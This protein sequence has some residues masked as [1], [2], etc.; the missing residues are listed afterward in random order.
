VD[1]LLGA[2]ADLWAG[3]GREREDGG[4]DGAAAVEVLLEGLCGCGDEELLG[5]G[6]EALDGRG[7]LGERG[8]EGLDRLERRVLCAQGLRVEVRGEEAEEVEGRLE[9]LALVRGGLCGLRVGRELVEGRQ[10]GDPVGLWGA[11]VRAER[12]VDGEEE[13]RRALDGGDLGPGLGADLCP[14][15]VEGGSG[16]GGGTAVRVPVPWRERA[17]E[18]GEPARGLARA[19]RLRCRGNCT[20]PARARTCPNQQQ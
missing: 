3:V 9:E 10:E 8:E 15:G 1:G 12:V 7:V 16:H 20:A 5:E 19:R 2:A 4:V 6:D 14:L 13:V 17:V 11:L 18:G